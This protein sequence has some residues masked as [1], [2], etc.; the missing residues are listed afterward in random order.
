MCGCLGV[1]RENT[2]KYGAVKDIVGGL[3]GGI[4]SSAMGSPALQ[5]EISMQ[6]NEGLKGGSIKE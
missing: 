2:A 1:F 5:E 4:M 6:I 3:F